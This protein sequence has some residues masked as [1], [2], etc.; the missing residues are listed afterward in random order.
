M[1]RRVFPHTP[2][3]HNEMIVR[4]RPSPVIVN[5][6][7]KLVLGILERHGQEE[8]GIHGNFPDKSIFRTVLLH[9]GLYKKDGNG[10][11]GYV[12]PRAIH[13]PGLQSV[14]RKIQEFLTIPADVPKDIASFLNE[15]IAPPFGVRA[16][17]LP[18]LF[19]AG[20]KAFPSA[21][22]LTRNGQY[23]DDI[24]P[25]EIEQLCRSPQDYRLAVLDLDD[26]R[27][28]YLRK[29][30]RLFTSVK[31]YEAAEN[32]LIRLCYDAIESWKAQLPPAAFSTRR[33]SERTDRCRAAFSRTSDPLRLLFDAIPAACDASIDKPKVLFSR[34]QV[35]MDELSGVASIYAGH[36][37]ATVRH[38]IALGGDP[39][40]DTIR[41]AAQSWASCFSG[42]FIE[43]LADGVA[44]GLLARMQ[45]PYD[46]DELLLDSLSSVLI[47]KSLS[48]WDDS[49]VAVFDR[50]L[51]N[52]VRRIED[53]ALSS[54]GIL[55]NSD[56]G[57][58]GMVQL[59]RGRMAEF[60]ER[61]AKL[62]GL[63]EARAM[64]ESISHQQESVKHG[65]D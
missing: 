36:A 54:D 14:W 1:M 28:S 60:F 52:M 42:S 24:L 55:S 8:V 47:G 7:K 34:L 19:A 51:H 32:D 18:V 49:T 10:R 4:K 61:L 11:W 21:I 2:R 23:V 20:L 31:G 40:H 35:C 64:L 59:V 5:S 29:L 58:N 12:S 3:I 62:V 25:S 46:S 17:L 53:I 39:Q 13:D 38:N 15:L 26:A 33:L 6:R 50:E 63:K 30:H 65:N 45:M 44:K 43:S 27:I 48:R 37:A 9:T 41:A 22:S 56:G 16:G 57:D